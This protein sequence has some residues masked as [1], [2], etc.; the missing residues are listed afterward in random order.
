MLKPKNNGRSPAADS[1][2]RMGLLRFHYLFCGGSKIFAS[3]PLLFCGGS[4]VFAL[5]PSLGEGTAS[6]ASSVGLPRPLNSASCRYISLAPAPPVAFSPPARNTRH[7][8]QAPPPA[9][10]SLLTQRV[11]HSRFLL[12]H[13]VTTSCPRHPRTT[14]APG[15]PLCVFVSHQSASG[16]SPG[17]PPCIR[18][19]F[20]WLI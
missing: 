15:S 19:C 4:K 8:S 14:P 10:V 6:P 1:Y 3:L 18:A 7:D 5:M 17:L 12:H 20:K 13:R 2:R 9:T 11:S 16:D